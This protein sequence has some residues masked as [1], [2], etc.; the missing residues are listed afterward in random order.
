MSDTGSIV[1][2]VALVSMAAS[3]WPKLSPPMLRRSGQ[4]NQ[5][6]RGAGPDGYRPRAKVTSAA[7]AARRAD[8]VASG[9]LLSRT[10]ARSLR[11]STQLVSAD[12][13]DLRHIDSHLIKRFL[14]HSHACSGG[15]CDLVELSHG[16]V[17]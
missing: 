4:R 10:E 5:S 6:R 7:T 11:T 9:R 14:Q 12:R 2:V 3:L 16:G 13:E 1:V 8:S 17:V 15:K